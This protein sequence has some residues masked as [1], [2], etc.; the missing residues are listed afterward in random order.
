MGL[1]ER[2]LPARGLIRVST[3]DFASSRGFCIRKPPFS[4]PRERLY[5]CLRVRLFCVSTSNRIH[6]SARGLICVLPRGPFFLPS[7]NHSIS[8]RDYSRAQ[9]GLRFTPRKGN[10]SLFPQ[11]ASCF[12]G[13]LYS[14]KKN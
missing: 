14:R 1:R 11:G 13:G 7:S 10:F 2:L 12:K 9:K 8:A 4:C 6:V 3:R 5:L